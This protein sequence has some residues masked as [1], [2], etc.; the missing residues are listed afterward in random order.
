M[1]YVGICFI[2]LEN[3]SYWMNV[4]LRVCIIGGHGLQYN[5]LTGVHVLQEGIFYWMISFTGGH[6][7]Y[8]YRFH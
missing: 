3:I 8:E 4:Y 5:S 2:L 1:A 7:L 6:L